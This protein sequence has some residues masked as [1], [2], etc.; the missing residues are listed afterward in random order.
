ML[1]YLNMIPPLKVNCQYLLLKPILNCFGEVF[2]KDV[3]GGFEVGDGAGELDEA[4]VG[5]GGEVHGGNGLLQEH[6]RGAVERADFA[7]EGGSHFGIGEYALSFEAFVL[8]GTGFLDSLSDSET[9]FG[10]FR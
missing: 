10:I 6:F 8:Y 1:R 4:V 5:A 7:D 3:V 2:G 9:R